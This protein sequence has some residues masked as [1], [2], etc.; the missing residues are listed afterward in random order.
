MLVMMA[1]ML[2]AGYDEQT[3]CMLVMLTD[4]LYAGYDEQTYCM[5]VMM[6]R[7]V[8]CWL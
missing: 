8:V 6:S 4:M 1:D 3:C 2:Y 7:H 5:L